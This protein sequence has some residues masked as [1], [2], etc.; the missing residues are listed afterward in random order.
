MK[1]RTQKKTGTMAND[2][3]PEKLCRVPAEH[4]WKGKVGWGGGTEDNTQKT[5]IA[6]SSIASSHATENESN[7][8]NPCHAEA[9]NNCK[10]LYR[11]RQSLSSC[12]LFI[13]H[14]CFSKHKP[15]ET[16]MEKPFWQL[17]KSDSIF[18]L[19]CFLLNSWH[20]ISINS[21]VREAEMP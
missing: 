17:H 16:W 5:R 11:R 13:S 19:F 4:T 8:E 3:A 18:S 15:D 1:K 21:T 14:L 10:D 2:H 7:V 12:V 20:R 6:R 9:S